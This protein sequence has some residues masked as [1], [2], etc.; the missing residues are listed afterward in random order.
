[1]SPPCWSVYQ[2]QMW[3]PPVSRLKLIHTQSVRQTSEIDNQNVN[4]SKWFP[5]KVSGYHMNDYFRRK[6]PL[7][8]GIYL[9]MVFGINQ[10]RPGYGKL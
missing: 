2:Q 4:I 7:G 10:G 6:H 1:M 9:N 8:Q 3:G 5:T